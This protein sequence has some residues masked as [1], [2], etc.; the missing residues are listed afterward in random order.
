[1]RQRIA[2]DQDNVI[3]DLLTEWLYRYNNDYNDNLTKEQVTMWNWHSLTKPEC[4]EKIYDYLDDPDLFLNLPVI[5]HSQEV[6]ET[7]NHYYDIYIVTS[8]FNFNNIVPKAKWLEKHFPFIPRERYVFTRDKS[9]IKASALI[10]DKPKNLETFE[11]LRVLFTAPHNKTER[12][13]VRAD[14]WGRIKD[15]YFSMIMNDIIG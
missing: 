9:I 10:D 4:G 2:V 12:R 14:N 5:E 11:G 1:M 6:L 7:L 8:P 3:A 15:I 13:F